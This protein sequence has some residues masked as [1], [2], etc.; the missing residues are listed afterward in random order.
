MTRRG[1]IFIIAWWSFVAL[2]VVTLVL[3]LFVY[4]LTTLKGDDMSPT[5]GPGSW[6]LVNRLA[7]PRPGDLVMMQDPAERRW[8]VRR[9]VA[10]AGDKI[11]MRGARPVVNG[12]E[13]T[14]VPAREL[15]VDKQEV[16]IWKETLA[17]RSYQVND[18]VR[19]TMHDMPEQAVEGGYWVLADNR[20]AAVRDSRTYGPVPKANIRGVVTWVMKR[21]QLP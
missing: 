3:R 16:R 11:A 9:V 17:G 7:T 1:R 5:I 14:L 10:V 20:E 2:A 19:R 8:Q 15:I 13:A 6:L 21:G 12:V 18:L 4:D